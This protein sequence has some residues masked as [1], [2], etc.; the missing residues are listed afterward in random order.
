VRGVLL[1]Q[2]TSLDRLGPKVE[3]GRKRWESGGCE[4]WMRWYLQFARSVL[5]RWLREKRWARG[6][7]HE[8]RR[9]ERKKVEDPSIPICG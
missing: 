9:K 7:E 1:L 5:H 6:D 3:G 8:H 2:V 4:G